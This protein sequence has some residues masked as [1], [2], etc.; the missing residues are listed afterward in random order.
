M[1]N[2]RSQIDFK[3]LHNDYLIIRNNTILNFLI[4]E[5]IS[6]KNH[7]HERANNILRQAEALES[8]NQNK[9]INEVMSD[10][11]NSVDKAYAEH[12]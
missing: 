12:R 10:T 5:Q 7:L 8:M 6:L 1:A 9:I 11:L 2:A 3:S 4:N